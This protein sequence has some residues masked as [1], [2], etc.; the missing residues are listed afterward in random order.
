MGRR[1]SPAKQGPA[2]QIRTESSAQV[3]R[4]RR[5]AKRDGR[6]LSDWIRRALDAAAESDDE[7]GAP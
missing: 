4:W 6:S 7:S 1:M 2:I 5:A 3:E